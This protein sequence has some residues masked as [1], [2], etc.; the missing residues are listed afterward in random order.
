MIEAISRD[1]TSLI[2]VAKLFQLFQPIGG[3]G[4]STPVEAP[5]V[6]A[7][8]AA[9]TATGVAPI[10]FRAPRRVR[11]IPFMASA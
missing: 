9:E 5:E 2:V 8:P 1:C 11:L 7:S 10:R 3:R 6:C 4:A